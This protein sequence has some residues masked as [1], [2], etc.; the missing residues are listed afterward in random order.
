MTM[1]RAAAS[2]AAGRRRR[3]R[4]RST[5]PRPTIPTRPRR[6]RTQDW[7]DRDLLRVASGAFCSGPVH[8]ARGWCLCV[9]GEADAGG[10]GWG[11]ASLE[12]WAEAVDGV[13]EAFRDR[14]VGADP[15]NIEEIWKVGYRGG[16]SRGGAPA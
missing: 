11:E 4:M 12:G 5:R 1:P 10:V 13:F 16:F 8:C 15:F 14:F 6:D 2:A 9:R 3:R 7:Q